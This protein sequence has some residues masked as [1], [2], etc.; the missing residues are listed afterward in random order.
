LAQ[1]V[2]FVLSC[3]KIDCGVRAVDLWKKKYIYLKLYIHLKCT[4]TSTWVRPLPD[5]SIESDCWTEI[6]RNLRTLPVVAL[7]NL[8]NLVLSIVVLGCV[9]KFWLH[10][11]FQNII[12][13]SHLI[14]YQEQHIMN[15]RGYCGHLFW[16]KSCTLIETHYHNSNR[17]KLEHT[18]SNIWL[19]HQE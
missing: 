1:N 13:N 3:I 9:A 12:R 16:H 6:R 8:Q 15:I 4:F 5:N 14:S 17:K 19:I 18:S 10:T 11:Y 2:S 7:L